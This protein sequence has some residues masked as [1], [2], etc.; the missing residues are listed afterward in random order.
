[1]TDDTKWKYEQRIVQEIPKRKVFINFQD[2]IKGWFE[3][4]VKFQK[5]T[6]DSNSS[7]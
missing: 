4:F 5:F 7:Y 2:V 3:G 6:V 1:M